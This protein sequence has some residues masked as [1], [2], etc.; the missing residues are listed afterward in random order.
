MDGVNQLN[1][2]LIIGMTNRLDM[3]D[4][5]LLRP[6]RLEVPVEISLPDEHGRQQ[7]LNIQTANMRKNSVM[8]TDV[9]LG[10]LAALT[11]NFS[12][13]EIAG[14]VKSATSFAFSRHVKVGTTA[15]ISDDVENMRVNRDDFFHALDEVHPAFGVS[16]DDLQ[17]V[18]ANG[19]M[20]F[21]PHI[22][23]ILR[24]GA[25]R[26]AQVRQSS[27]TP[28][29]TALLHGPVGSGKTALA[30]TVALQS[31]FPFIQIVSP[32]HMVGMNEPA[33]VQHINKVFNDAYKSPL[34]VIVVDGFEKLIEWVPIGP[35]FQNT[36]L[37][38]LSVLLTR[39][40]P[41]DKRLLVLVTSSNKPMLE[42]ME[43][44]QS[45]YADIAVPSIESLR[46]VDHVLRATALFE[47][48]DDHAR[49]MTL[50][51]QAGLGTSKP[52]Q[53]GIKKLISEIE[54]ARFD[55]D[56]ADKLLAALNFL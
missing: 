35:R 22:D 36:V 37:Q 53:I 20:Q 42:E 2:I 46:E 27:R 26:V 54:M 29:V 8:D 30:A 55:D 38:A 16:E 40:P 14:L 49:C 7:I 43:I 56:P 32:E 33:K 24:D 25:L 6:G 19:I 52:F 11:K 13:A 51:A 21:A 23:A 12:G 31:E 41:K 15:G 45:F 28:L 5:A 18:V 1:N 17:A 10:E 39:R 4:E 48:D 44:A 34:S 50:L 9:D 3:I 47:H